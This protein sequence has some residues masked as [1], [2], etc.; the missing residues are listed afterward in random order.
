MIDFVGE[1]IVA[2]RVT[3][4]P[5]LKTYTARPMA[6]SKFEVRRFKL[7]TSEFTLRKRLRRQESNLRR[8][9]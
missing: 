7:L 8:G 9:D 1:L 4:L 2:Q 6:R 5:P 3:F